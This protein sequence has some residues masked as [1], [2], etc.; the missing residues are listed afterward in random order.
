VIADL[1]R[2]LASVGADPATLARIEAHP[3]PAISAVELVL[4]LT[5]PA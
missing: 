3:A 2:E 4:L 1:L 5:R